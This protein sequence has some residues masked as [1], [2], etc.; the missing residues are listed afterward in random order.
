MS[1]M[2]RPVGSANKVATV[3]APVGGLNARD[4]LIAMPQ[5]DA[6]TMNNW[7]PQP[8][9][10]SIRKGFRE[11]TTGLPGTVDT[12]ATLATE[13][14]NELMFAWSGTAV[15][16]VT[17]RGPAGAPLLSGLGGANAARWQTLV[18]TND[19]GSNMLAVNGF[20][21]AIVFGNNGSATRIAAGDGTGSTWAGLDPKLAIQLT[22]HQGRVW[23]TQINSTKG[24]YLPVGALYGTMVSFDFGPQFKRG[25]YLAFLSTWTIDDGNGAED[26]LVAVSSMGEAVVYGGTDPADDTAWTQVG[27][28]FVGAPLPG[29]RSFAK[30]G[31]DLAILSQRGVISMAT[32]LASTKINESEA[33]IKTDQIQYLV[34]AVTTA[35]ASKY[36]WQLAYYPGI[37]MLLFN[38]P[39]NEDKPNRQLVSNQV[40][41]IQPWSTFSGMDAVCWGQFQ[42]SPMF[43]SKDG[44]VLQA[45]TGYSDNVNLDD[46]G[47]TD[48]T[49]VAQQ[50]YTSFG[51]P[52]V[53]K[54]I[55]MYRPNFIVSEP[56]AVSTE[57][58]YD[59]IRPESIIPNALRHISTNAITD[60]WN[61]GLWGV[62]IW[63]VGTVDPGTPPATS[64]QRVWIQGEGLG[65][66]ASLKLTVQAAT[67]VLWVSTDYS[68]K[69]GSL[70]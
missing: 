28:Y 41:S 60:G 10:I 1:W 64:A 38:I 45:W 51:A 42:M 70:L 17:V 36:G 20:D 44:R 19:A 49:A 31:A 22:S 6:V 56:V 5:E 47:G 68:Y 13:L 4:S 34:S 26:H 40:S 58:V 8:Y 7:W 21:D 12:I 67:E 69:V 30:V 66:S 39:N 65:V 59:F 55:D 24:W 50:A 33:A 14:G 63:G 37:N 35:Y 16:N 52:A 61:S 53:Q 3:P 57:I 9:G 18:V 23:A 2:Q 54:Q 27:V 25:G 11:W 46:L 48:I 62:A 29:R 32:L 15:Y 43:G